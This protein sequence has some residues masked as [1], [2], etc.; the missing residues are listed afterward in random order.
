[1]PY[2]AGFCQVFNPPIEQGHCPT[3][4]DGNPAHQD[5][6]FDLGYAAPVSV[7]I[8]STR[9][10][11]S[12]LMIYESV[13]TC[14]G[15]AG[16]KR[17]G[18]GAYIT[19]A[20]ATSLDYGH[21]WPTYRGTPSFSFVSL[22]KANDMQGPNAPSGALGKSVC[23]GNDCSKTPP[24]SYGRYPVLSPPVSLATIMAMG[25]PIDGK[26]GDAEPSAFVDDVSGSSAH[27]FISCT[28]MV[29]G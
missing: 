9:C 27:T 2:P 24:S 21:N 4:K 29:P 18:T 22:P 12:L 1:M 14:V 28:A 23:M 8:D 6:T 7:V 20:I 10:P 13:N 26:L 15:N 3:V 25:K 11:G 19:A 16:G 5:Q 17:S